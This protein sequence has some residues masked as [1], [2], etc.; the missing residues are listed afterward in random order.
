MLL[1]GKREY[2]LGHKGYGR[3]D[4]ETKALSASVA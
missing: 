4:K 3:I 1:D 2:P